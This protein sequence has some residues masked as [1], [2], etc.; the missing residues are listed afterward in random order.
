MSKNKVMRSE[1]NDKKIKEKTN[2]GLTADDLLMGDFNNEFD[3]EEWV[4]EKE[5]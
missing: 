1:K 2:N 5:E 4:Y 3:E